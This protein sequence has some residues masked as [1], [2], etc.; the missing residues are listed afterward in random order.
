M[1]PNAHSAARGRSC[2]PIRESA[3]AKIDLAPHV[4]ASLAVMERDAARMRASRPFVFTNIRAG[5]GVDAVIDFIEEKGGLA[6]GQ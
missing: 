4:G 3:L 1:V 6:T 5:E 2:S